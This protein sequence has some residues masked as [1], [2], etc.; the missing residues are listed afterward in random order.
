MRSIGTITKYYPFLNPE[1]KQLVDS[2][3]D[4]SENYR[5]FVDKL[6]DY[7]TNPG[8]SRNLLHLA[9]FHALEIDESSI[10]GKLCVTDDPFV[11][12]LNAIFQ[13]SLDDPSITDP[14]DIH[15][16]FQ[17]V[18][19]TDIEDWVYLHVLF[20]SH[21]L[22]DDAVLREN[23]IT[24]MKNLFNQNPK[25]ECFFPRFLCNEAFRL[26]REGDINSAL[27]LCN[28]ALN[29]ARELD[30]TLVIAGLLDCKA[31]IIK[32]DDVHAAAELIEEFYSLFTFL[33]HRKGRSS[34]AADMGN[35]YF[36]LGEYDFAL[37]FY[38]DAVRTFPDSLETSGDYEYV[39]AR[40]YNALGKPNEAKKWI[41]HGKEVENTLNLSKQS[42]LYHLAVAQTQIILGHKEKARQHLDMAREKVYK[43]GN[44]VLLAVYEYHEGLYEIS[45]GSVLNS[46]QS[47]ESALDVA[48]RLN[49]QII[50]NRCLLAMAKAEVLSGLSAKGSKKGETS[51]KWMSRLESHATKRNYVG[52]RMQHALLKAEYQIKQGELDKA[53]YTLTNA[54]ALSDSPGVETTRNNIQEQIEKLGLFHQA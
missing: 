15:I 52:I 33:D 25:L 20:Q 32:D 1:E 36:I 12:S 40:I 14:N 10:T 46:L 39:F 13:K 54:L 4:Q 35:V 27:D 50:G 28:E 22:I 8:T 29:H 49:I 51:S 45:F 30:D 2:I 43:T 26:R 44:E 11:N 21:D 42:P 5:D 31:S 53:M 9:V 41:E 37:K 17:T 18:L 23:Y 3:M 38:L 6:A 34:A 19:S 24:K 47:F 16:L 7:V 48:E